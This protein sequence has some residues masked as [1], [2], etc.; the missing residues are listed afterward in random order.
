MLTIFNTFSPFVELQGKIQVM[1][2]KLVKNGISTWNKERMNY[3]FRLLSWSHLEKVMTP[4]MTDL[5]IPE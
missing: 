2:I 1:F 4:W 3:H 5:T